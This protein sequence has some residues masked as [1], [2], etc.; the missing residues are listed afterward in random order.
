MPT[1]YKP[2]KLGIKVGTKRQVWWTT[3][4]DK[5]EENILSSEESLKADMAVLKI[6][7]QEI[8]KEEAKQQKV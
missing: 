1:T 8:A 3:I 5:I 4:R 7:N 6:A 2:E